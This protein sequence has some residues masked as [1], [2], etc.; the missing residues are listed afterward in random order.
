MIQTK[1]ISKIASCVGEPPAVMQSFTSSVTPRMEFLIQFFSG[2]IIS[3]QIQNKGNQQSNL[4][5]V[6]AGSDLLMS[7]LRP[8]PYLSAEIEMR[9]SKNLGAFLGSITRLN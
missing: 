9:G 3:R 2:L 6:S 4:F 8:N 7:T 5:L 1:N